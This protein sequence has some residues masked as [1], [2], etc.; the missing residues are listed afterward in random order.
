MVIALSP[1]W[2]YDVDRKTGLYVQDNTSESVDVF[3]LEEEV[4][5]KVDSIYASERKKEFIRYKCNT[6]PGTGDIDIPLGI[7]NRAIK[8]ANIAKTEDIYQYILRQNIIE[9]D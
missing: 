6:L 3:T 8:Y 1:N 5:E 2:K 4:V 7:I 9:G